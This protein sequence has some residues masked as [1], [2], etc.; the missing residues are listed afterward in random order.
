MQRPVT[1]RD[2]NLLQKLYWE[3]IRY[4]LPYASILVRQFKRVHVLIPD[5]YMPVVF[6]LFKHCLTY[7]PCCAQ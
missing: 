1:M 4:V 7:F 6:S 3:T 5:V 2:L